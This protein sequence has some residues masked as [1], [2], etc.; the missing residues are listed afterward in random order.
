MEKKCN[1]I[2]ITS[3][4]GWGAHPQS[5]DVLTI[6]HDHILYY[7]K[8]VRI[9]KLIESSSSEL[10]FDKEED[11]LKEYVSELFKLATNSDFEVDNEAYGCDGGMISVAICFDDGTENKVDVPGEN[12]K[13]ACP[14][15]YELLRILKKI[16]NGTSIKPIYLDFK[17][18]G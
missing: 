16:L 12:L 9:G 3:N 11:C 14:D 18:I 15:L 5:S 7:L 6:F 17:R 10:L 4:Y 13:I 2:T 1:E 8:V